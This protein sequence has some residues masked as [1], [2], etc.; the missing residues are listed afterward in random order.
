MA[1]P[2]IAVLPE[3]SPQLLRD[4]VEEGGGHLVEVDRADAVMWTDSSD[5][6]ALRAA[7]DA[8]PAIRWVQLPWAGIE[9]FVDVLDDDRTWTCGKGV[10]AEPVAEH[11]LALALA[12]MRGIGRYARASR[13]SGPYGVNLLGGRVTILG[14]GAITTSLVRLLR[15]FGA[16]LTVVRRHAEPI[17][18]VAEVLTLDRLHEALE[19]RD[20][21]VLAL[22]LTPETEQVIDAAALDAMADHAWL[23]NVA[24]GRHVVTDD[25][26]AALR[27][28]RIGGA[29]LDVTD[30]EPL[31]EGHPLWSLE[32]AIV[33][34]HV[35]NTPEMGRKLL[36]NRIRENVQRFG[37]GEDLLGPVHVEL[38]Y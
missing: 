23:I 27:E 33:T 35:G 13:W 8:H 31:P 19:G 20:L 10:Y 38:G 28:G 4:A 32:N 15:P 21:V 11:V 12:G 7:L 30:P 16:H 9:P 17:D 6:G 5:P 26:V 2:R 37:D 25:L 18:G 29:A 22:A 1:R 36:A 24:R 34:P 3:S 14:G